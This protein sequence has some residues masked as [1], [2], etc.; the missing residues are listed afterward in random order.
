MKHI[1]TGMGFERLTS[2]VQD[3]QSN[4]ETDTFLTLFNAIEKI[5][6]NVGKYTNKY[7]END[8]NLLDTNYRIMADHSRM[9]AI[10]LADG[11]IPEL[12]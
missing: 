10:C 11:M 5:C 1:D 12:K 4:Y 8:W 3:V 2:I 6:P 7:G 9:I